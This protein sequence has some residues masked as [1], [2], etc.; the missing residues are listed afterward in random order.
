MEYKY[1]ENCMKK[2][3]TLV[4]KV[5]RTLTHKGKTVTLDIEKRICKV[6]S[7]QVYDE[8]LDQ[9]VSEDFII[10][11]NKN[12]GVPG[13]EIRRFRKSYRL[14]QEQF[15]SLLGIAPKTLISYEKNQAIPE[16]SNAS[17]LCLVIEEPRLLYTLSKNKGIELPEKVQKAVPKPIEHEE[18]HELNEFNGFKDKDSERIIRLIKY[19]SSLKS[20]SM[21]KLNK[22]FFYLDFSYFKNQGK[23]FTGLS[24]LKHQY[25][26]FTQ[27][28]YSYVQDLE[29][30]GEI[31]KK[32][33]LYKE[34]TFE[35]ISIV[36]KEDII[37]KDQAVNNI[38]NNMSKFLLNTNAEEIS[39]LSHQEEAWIK[40][41]FYKPISYSY[42]LTLNLD[43]VT[44]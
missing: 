4:V 12:H 11:F 36:K 21:T 5:N 16:T 42:A 30:Q 1:C 34:K 22:A 15:S 13:D 33:Y 18:L 39:D 3:E 24:Y 2:V 23:S 25:G 29:Q 26:P 38:L 35:S 17:L 37:F 32:E 7:E 31:T 14:T 20:I 10:A 41:P 8:V 28:L 44:Q 40:T 6:C 19:F 43:F 9:K 27:S